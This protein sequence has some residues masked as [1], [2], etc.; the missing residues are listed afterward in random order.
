MKNESKLSD[1][2]AAIRDTDNSIRLFLCGDVMAG[3][4]IDQILPH[5][6]DPQI[7]ES[8]VK[9]A[10]DYVKLGERVSGS[11]DQPVSYDYIWGDAME[12]WQKYDP[13]LKI[14]NLETS[15][16]DNGSP[17]PGKGIQY[18]M[19]PENMPVFTEAG[20]DFISLAN[21]HV[22]DWSRPGL[23]ETLNAVEKADIAYAGAGEDIE[24]AKEPAILE[25]EKGRVII[26]A[27]GHNSSG[28][29]DAWAATEERSGVN[30]LKNFDDSAVQEIADQVNEFK[31]SGDIVIFSV[32]WGSNWGYAIPEQQVEFAHEL[33][34]N[35]GVDIIHGHS[36]HHPRPLEVYKNK[37]IIYGAGDFINDYE[38]IGGEEVYRGDLTLM[39]FPD[40]D[41]DSGDLISMR[42][43]PMQIRNFQLIKASSSDI[44]WLQNVL[45]NQSEQF[46]TNV[47]RD[48]D[49]T[50]L[51]KW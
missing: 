51:L 3:R 41:P 19:H 40:V 15:V 32:H 50:L 13:D 1:T 20:I 21:N 18:R 47:V 27:Y 42:M 36:S 43:V 6:V 10:R 46:N 22:L 14:I 25:T 37:L 49:G 12:V 23:A 7:Y 34:D 26:F 16:T 38:G 5:S 28:V 2:S 33:I 48:E 29:P 45:D 39:Y 4:G 24:Q 44:K 35:A 11:I 8:Y 31:K 30:L 17:W 9:D